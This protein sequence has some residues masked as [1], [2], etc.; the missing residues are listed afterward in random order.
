MSVCT[1]ALYDTFEVFPMTAARPWVFPMLI[2][3]LG[4]QGLS[5]AEPAKERPEKISYYRNIRPIFELNCQGC[6]QPAQAKGGFIMTGYA[7]LLKKGDSDKPGIVPGKPE[8]SLIFEQITPQGNKPPEMPKGKNP[9]AA[10]DVLLIKQWIAEGALDDTPAI[11]R[12][13]VDRDHPPV[14]EMAP[15]ITA[16]DYSPDG[17]LLAVSGYHEVLIHKADGSGL[18]ARL[19]GLSERIQ[20]VAF[21]PNGKLLAVAGGSPGRFGEIQIWNVEKKKLDVSVSVTNDTVYGARWS[22]D[23]TKVSFGCGD[24]TVRAI[25]AGTG[26]QVLYQGAHNDWVL[27]TIF[28][29]TGS[30]LIS[31]SR[32]MSMK[33]TEVATQRFVDNITSIT[34]GALKG[35]LMSVDRHPK[36]EEVLIGGSDGVPKIYRI[37]RDPKKPR[38]IGDDFNKIVAFAPMPGRVF[39]VRFSPDG[40]RALAGSSA[41]GKGEVRIYQA[42]DGKLLATLAGEKGPVFAVAYRPDGK[43][44]ASAG[45]DGTVRLNDAQTGKLIKEFVPVTVLPRTLKTAAGK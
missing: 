42:A 21:S 25:E 16:L 13:S 3:G 45:F 26:K 44:V 43:E 22:P 23:G 12:Q 17:K 37:F 38:Q 20:A 6:H 39:C 4:V 8:Q 41:M 7:A 24:N 11:A 15:V 30:H 14:Y 19:I 33:L 27:D 40:T 32:D 28:S 36:K 34:P 18:V 2:L 10:R 29:L 9:L 35:G 1:P 31:V 5:A